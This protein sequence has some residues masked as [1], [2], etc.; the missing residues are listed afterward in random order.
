V[1]LSVSELA[2]VIAPPTEPSKIARK[3]GHH[4]AVE[5]LPEI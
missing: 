1:F 5:Q 4:D 2:K 3:E